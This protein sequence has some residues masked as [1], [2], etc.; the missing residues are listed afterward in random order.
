MA[1]SLDD[2]W[3]RVWGIKTSITEKQKGM[4]TLNQLTLIAVL[5]P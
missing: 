3:H 5:L 2:G 1:A 4:N